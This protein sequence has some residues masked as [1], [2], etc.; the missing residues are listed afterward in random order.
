MG[1]GSQVITL[2]DQFDKVLELAAVVRN[3]Y[4]AKYTLSSLRP[5]LCRE[6]LRKGIGVFDV[7]R[8]MGTPVQVIQT[9][10]GRH[11]TPRTLAT[12]LGG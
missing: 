1:D 6:S 2:I 5:L 4:G 3:S 10:Y 7:A 8:N 9:Y 12:Q 11:A